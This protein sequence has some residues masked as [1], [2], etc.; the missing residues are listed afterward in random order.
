[1]ADRRTID[2]AAANRNGITRRIPELAASTQ[3]TTKQASTR[4][5]DGGRCPTYSKITVGPLLDGQLYGAVAA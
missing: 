1:M 2:G 4:W 3:D 5:P